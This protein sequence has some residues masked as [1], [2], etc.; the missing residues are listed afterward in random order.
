MKNSQF[1]YNSTE[2]MDIFYKVNPEFDESREIKLEYLSETTVKRSTE[3]PEAEVIFTLRVFQ[4]EDFVKVPF[5]IKISIKGQ[6]RWEEEFNDKADTLLKVNA[7]A[8]L[9]SYI[10]PFIAQFTAFSGFPPLILPLIDFTR[11]DR[12]MGDA[13]A[14]KC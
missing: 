9:L 13:S 11:T 7:P 8:T 12:S 3:K 6:F 10:R 4:E 5:V 1:Q 14:K 2:K